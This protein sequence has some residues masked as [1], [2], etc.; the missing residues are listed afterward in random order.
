METRRSLL[1]RIETSE[2]I[3]HLLYD[4]RLVIP[5]VTRIAHEIL[6]ASF[7]K[8]GFGGLSVTQ[9]VRLIVR[10]HVLKLQD[11]IVGTC[12]GLE[13]IARKVR[14]SPFSELGGGFPPPIGTAEM[15]DE[16]V[17]LLLRGKVGGKIV[18]D[19]CQ[20][21]A[22]QIVDNLCLALIES[23]FVKP[24]VHIR[25]DFH[26]WVIQLD[27]VPIRGFRY[28]ASQSSAEFLLQFPVGFGQGIGPHPLPFRVPKLIGQSF[29][30]RI[31]FISTNLFR[32]HICRV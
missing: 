12:H 28:A 9:K 19:G 4:S 16:P 10:H 27:F 21:F 2:S 25:V 1:F 22:S 31:R 13:S 14:F 3:L 26:P 29:R 6:K 7:A 23:G 32:V 24:V 11:T 30:A 18:D 17:P 8:T 5:P 15:L 20:V